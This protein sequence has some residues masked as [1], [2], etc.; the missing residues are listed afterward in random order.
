MLDIFKKDNAELQTT[1][2]F[3]PGDK[4]VVHPELP[5][6]D[7][8][9]SVIP[10]MLRFASKTVTIISKSSKEYHIRED[11]GTYIWQD[12]MFQSP[13]LPDAKDILDLIQ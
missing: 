6:T 9:P 7:K 4:A 1:Y 10:E 13:S 8:W 2:W 5:L 3:K 12:W 11:S